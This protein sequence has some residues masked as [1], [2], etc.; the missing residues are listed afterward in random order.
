MNLLLGFGY[1]VVFL[2]WSP[3]MVFCIMRVRPILQMKP[4]ACL[5]VDIAFPGVRAIDLS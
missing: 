2:A 4:S 5:V 3:G 1:Y